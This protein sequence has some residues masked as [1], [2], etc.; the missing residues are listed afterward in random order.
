MGTVPVLLVF[1]LFTT[2][3]LSF[4]TK[5]VV[6]SS[7]PSPYTSMNRYSLILILIFLSSTY[8]SLPCFLPPFPLFSFLPLPSSSST[9]I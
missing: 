9:L 1:L 4:S 5:A 2:L 8:S 3:A 6:V 7:A